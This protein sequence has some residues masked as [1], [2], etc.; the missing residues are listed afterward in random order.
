MHDR[1]PDVAL[2]PEEA[3]AG[4]RKYRSAEEQDLARLKEAINRTPDEKFSFLMGLMRLQ[5]LMQESKMVQKSD[6]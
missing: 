4:I 6:Q 1:N 3:A 5:R 2:T